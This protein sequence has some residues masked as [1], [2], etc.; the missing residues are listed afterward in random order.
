MGEPSDSELLH[1]ARQG[2]AIPF[3]TLVRRHDR[4]LYRVARSVLA[5]TITN[6]DFTSPK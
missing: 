5:L 2:D 3:G 6:G 4:Y 1:R